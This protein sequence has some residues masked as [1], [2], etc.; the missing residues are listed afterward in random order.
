VS[1]RDLH[2]ARDERLKNSVLEPLGAGH[3]P[4]DQEEI[5]A[6]TDPSDPASLPQPVPVGA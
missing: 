2:G 5:D 4:R 1:V 6:G 3:R